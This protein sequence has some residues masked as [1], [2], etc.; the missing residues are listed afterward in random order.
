MVERVPQG[1]ARHHPHPL[2]Q[3]SFSKSLE[4]L[5]NEK[6]ECGWYK[7]SVL[8]GLNTFFS[9]FT[10]SR[11]LEGG[12]R[13]QLEARAPPPPPRDVVCKLSMKAF[14]RSVAS[15]RSRFHKDNLRHLSRFSDLFVTLRIL[16]APPKTRESAKVQTNKSQ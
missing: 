13:V 3:F 9:T 5:E 8:L 12:E 16:S 2:I 4:R 15:R 10:F 1:R 11:L 14:E 7:R 6:D